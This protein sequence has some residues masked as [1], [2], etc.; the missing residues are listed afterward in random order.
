MNPFLAVEFKVKS[1]DDNFTEESV[2]LH[3]PEELFTYVAPGGGCEQIPSEVDE[4]NMVFL[5]EAHRNTLNPVADLHA[6]LELG[7]VYFNGPLAEISQVAE[8]IVDRAGRG[9]LSDAFLIVIGAP[10]RE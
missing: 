5:P 6:T 3:S 1:D 7:L 8:Q 10:Q 4:I 9:E 2:A